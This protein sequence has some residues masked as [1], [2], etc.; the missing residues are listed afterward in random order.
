L[1]YGETDAV[2][3]HCE[4][5]EDSKLRDLANRRETARR[6]VR[7]YSSRALLLCRL[8]SLRRRFGLFGRKVENVRRGVVVVLA[9]DNFHSA[10]GVR[11]EP[12]DPDERIV[13]QRDLDA[14]GIERGDRSLRLT[15]TGEPLDDL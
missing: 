11:V 10:Q 5:S 9:N 4:T 15:D 8:F 6:A 3:H 1:A 14:S 12:I 13:E 7:Q 2:Q